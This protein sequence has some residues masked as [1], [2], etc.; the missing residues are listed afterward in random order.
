MDTNSK[1]SNNIAVVLVSHG[2][3]LP[4]AEK[5]FSEIKDKFIEATGLPTE[6]GYMKVAEPSISGAV[7]YLKAENPEVDKIFALPVF[8]APGI[9]TNIDIPIL[10]GLEPLEADPRCPDG[11]Y[12]DDH[13]LSIADDVDF[14]GEIE[15]IEPIGAHEAIL[16]VINKRIEEV[17]TDSELDDSA[18]TGILLVSH[19]SRLN[20]NKEFI[21]A[22]HR[23]F[24]EIC[25]Y[26]NTYGFM[27]LVEPN[28]PTSINNLLE[29]NELDRLVVVPVFIAPGVHTTSDIPTILGLKEMEEHHHHHDH[30]H[31]HGHHHHHDLEPIE[32]DGEILY[33]EPI[34]ADDILIEI[35]KEKIE[36]KLWLTDK[37]L[38]TG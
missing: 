32:F 31:D 6:V 1:S 2:S 25:E 38:H 34:G 27:E 3:S 13:Y 23:M 17:L 8:L 15:L 24:D 11:N 9:H 4:Y 18:K 37:F 10:L 21:S 12:P 30:E 36:E 16:D 14:D 5:T 29:D 26:P 20:Y 28:I 33:P 35:L 22:V 19:G 7:D